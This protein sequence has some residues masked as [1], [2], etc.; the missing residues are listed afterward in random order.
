MKLKF[1]CKRKLQKLQYKKTIDYISKKNNAM[2]FLALKKLSAM[3]SSWHHINIAC[4]DFRS[5][6]ILVFFKYENYFRDM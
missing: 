5:Q 2:L 3:S 1:K 4:S 6:T